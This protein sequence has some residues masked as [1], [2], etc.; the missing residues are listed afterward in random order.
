[1][2]K[3]S[4]EQRLFNLFIKLIPLFL[5]LFLILFGYLIFKLIINIDLIKE[6]PLKYG[7]EQHKYSGCV[8]YKEGG[9]TCYQTN[10][11]FRCKKNNPYDINLN[12]V[13]FNGAKGNN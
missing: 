11:G 2:V 3:K 1:M 8:C 10:I 7:L 13:V 4:N 6:D 9:Y 5:F 12:E